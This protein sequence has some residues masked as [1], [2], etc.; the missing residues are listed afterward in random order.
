MR[1]KRPVINNNARLIKSAMLK[2]EANP[3]A[4]YEEVLSVEEHHEAV[5]MMR[6]AVAYVQGHLAA[7]EYK[8]K[9]PRPPHPL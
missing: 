2:L 5:L 4:R 7:Q 1:N 8:G 9:R 6:A 3:Y